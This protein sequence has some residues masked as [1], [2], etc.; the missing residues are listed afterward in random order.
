VS[1]AQA[2]RDAPCVDLLG[3]AGVEKRDGVTEVPLDGRPERDPSPPNFSSERRLIST[4]VSAANTFAIEE[5]MREFTRAETIRYN[6]G[7]TL[8]W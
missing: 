2:V 4:A 1:V 7:S 5:T 3:P 6:T 8:Q